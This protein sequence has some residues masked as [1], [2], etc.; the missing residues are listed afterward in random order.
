LYVIFNNSLYT[1]ESEKPTHLIGFITY[2]TS[3]PKLIHVLKPNFYQ[4]F[5][6]WIVKLNRTT[7]IQI[8]SDGFRDREFSI[9]KPDNTFRIIVL[10]DSNT[11]GQ[12]VEIEE[13]YSKVLENKLNSIGDRNY[14]VMNF[15]VPAYNTQD[16][17][18]F[19]KDVGLKYNPDLVIVGFFANDLEDSFELRELAEEKMEENNYK[20]ITLSDIDKA[21]FVTDIFNDVNGKYNAK[22]H[23]NDTLYNYYWNKIVVSSFIDLADI[24]QESNFDIVI[25]NINIREGKYRLLLENITSENNWSLINAGT[26]LSKYDVDSLTVSK[27]DAH[28]NPLGH[29]IIASDIYNHL[30]D[31]GVI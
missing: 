10:G 5:D 29:D 22:L 31:N 11:F 16:E 3:N 12:G 18:E 15:G 19:F 9:E 7:S 13:T 6:G 21:N 17:V 20:F 24:G 1:T 23:A 4:E 27:W 30:I 28:Y 14:E 26:S 8:N 2:N 25:I